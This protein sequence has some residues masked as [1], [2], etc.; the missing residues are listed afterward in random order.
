M[1]A[2]CLS[3]T[4]LLQDPESFLPKIKNRWM[5]GAVTADVVPEAWQETIQGAQ[6]NGLDAELAVLALTGQLLQVAYR[7]ANGQPL[8][9]EQPLP[10]LELPPLPEKL[11]SSFRRLLAA[12]DGSD[13]P[14]L[15]LIASRG[16]TVSPLDWMPAAREESLPSVY[17]PWLGWAS[18]RSSIDGETSG[19]GLDTDSWSDFLP[20]ERRRALKALRIEAADTARQLIE[21]QGLREAAEERAKIIAVLAVGLSENDLPLLVKLNESDR[22]GKVKSIAG[23]LLARLGQ[24]QCSD[25]DCKEL[26]DFLKVSKKGLINR[27]RQVSPAKIKTGAQRKR[28]TELLESVPFDAL[29]G[30]LKQTPMELATEW[31]FNDKDGVSDYL[32]QMIVNTAADEIIWP[33]AQ[34]IVQR[35]AI[36]SINDDLL[37]RLKQLHN[38]QINSE[39]F[40]LVLDADN[41]YFDSAVR[42]LADAPGS[43]TFEQLSKTNGYSCL[44]AAAKKQAKD[45]SRADEHLLQEGLSN[46]GLIATQEAAKEL[47]EQFIN[48]GM[49]S[50]D[51]GLACLRFNA[52][53]KPCE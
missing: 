50:V 30:A 27:K 41:G 43:V 23:N 35:D 36:D 10:V 24:S 34:N 4:D 26:A 14:L 5:I 2:G 44:L 22:S 13:V 8:L 51:P 25:E 39:I 6:G 1:L 16:Y 12:Q 33:F 37:K 18:G 46:L 49:M 7:P 21:D 28:R 11:R 9:V 40:Q 45:D 31:V 19:V 48:A 17:S 15:T 53:L 47:L 52:D 29:A 42:Y 38:P 20:A 3:M 32:T